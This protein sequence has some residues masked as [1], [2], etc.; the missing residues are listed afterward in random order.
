MKQEELSI[1]LSI[2]ESISTVKNMNELFLLIFEKMQQAYPFQLGGAVIFNKNKTHL[3]IFL[4][5]INTLEEF[6]IPV[7]MYDKMPVNK[8]PI[9]ISFTNPQIQRVAIKNIID[10][11]EYDNLQVM[12]DMA[13]RGGISEVLHIPLQLAGDV[14]G[15]LILAFRKED[16]LQDED[17]IFFQQLSNQ[18]AVLMSSSMSYYET[19]HREQIKAFLLELTNSLAVVKDRDELFIK[20]FSEINKLLSLD[21]VCISLREYENSEN[22]TRG[23]KKGREGKLYD[24]KM[25]N[26]IDIPF[27]LLKSRVN[28][29]EEE[30]IYEFVNED[31]DKLCSQSAYFKLLKENYGITNILYINYTLYDVGEI[32]YILAKDGKGGA[33]IHTPMSQSKRFHEVDIEFILTILPQIKLIIMNFFAFEEIISLRNKL[34]EEKNYLLDE[35]KLEN[36]FQEIIGNSFEIQNVLTKV[37]Q[38]APLHVNVLIQGETGTGKELIARAIHNLSDRKDRTLV[39]INCAALPANLIESELFGHEKGSFTGAVEKRIGKFE[40][41]NGSTIFLDEIGELPLEL[42]SKLLRVLQEQEIERIGGRDTI[43]ID[44]RIISATNRNLEAEVE[45]GNF[46]KDLFFRLNVFPLNLPPLR[47]RT[48]DIPLFVKFFLEKYSKK[49]GKPVKAVKKTDL[50]TLMQYDWPG[51]IR[52]LEHLIEKSVIISNGPN[53]EFSDFMMVKSLGSKVDKMQFKPLA[54]M[55]RDYIIAALKAVNGK[56]TGENSAAKLLNINGKTLSSKMAK[57]NIK[58]EIFIS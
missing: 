24:L 51:N 1:L 56:I 39:K 7:E 35:I 37:Q 3:E 50:D 8:S 13:L 16:I 9:K 2:I 10:N 21:Y 6:D 5:G 43:K 34:E 27:L 29:L 36:N 31:F 40:L 17:L 58:R 53:L 18:I 11:P 44:V 4:K 47:K 12:R 49:I 20:I 23:Y 41:A 15:V 46:R 42:Q 22:I 32:N 19:I 38:V 45:K 54:E 55:E 30:S 14:K 26:D 33:L 48:S 52:E 57:L 28:T 25:K